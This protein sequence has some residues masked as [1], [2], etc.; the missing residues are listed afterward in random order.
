[1]IELLQNNKLK[2]NL[3]VPKLRTGFFEIADSGFLVF[4]MRKIG[5]NNPQNKL[6]I[7][8][9]FLLNYVFF[10]L[11]SGFSLEFSSRCKIV[12]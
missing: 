1:M 3:A 7:R 4:K 8:I 5:K 12:C 6:W 10:W 11:T 2:N 9:S